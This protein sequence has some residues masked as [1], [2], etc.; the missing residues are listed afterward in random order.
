[1][2]S[3]EDVLEVLD[4]LH[5]A[6]ARCWIDGG[7]GVDALTRK[8]TRLHSD[9]DLVVE[10][11]AIPAVR[12]ALEV[13]G[14]TLALDALPTRAVLAHVDGRSIDLHPVRFDS[15]GTGWQAGAGIGGGDAEYPAYGFTTGII[16]SH[17]V[18][19]LGPEVQLRHHTGYEPSDKDIHDI[20][21]L[22]SALPKG[23]E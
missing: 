2:I 16:A 17:A 20:G 8:Q 13:L 22:R 11:D 19:C 15:E 10:L 9:L 21:L 18:P 6:G 3:A 12:S 4:A 14:Y 1:V 23:P 5:E 7:W